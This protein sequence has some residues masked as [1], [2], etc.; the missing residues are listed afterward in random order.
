MAAFCAVRAIGLSGTLSS[1]YRTSDAQ[2]RSISPENPTG[3]PSKGGMATTGILSMFVGATGL[4]LG[5]QIFMRWVHDNPERARQTAA[6]GFPST[7]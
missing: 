5:Y 4:A 1:L 6:S 7:S 3:E 2:T